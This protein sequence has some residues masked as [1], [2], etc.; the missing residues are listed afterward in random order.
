[1][2]THEHLWVQIHKFVTVGT[3]CSW[4]VFVLLTPP[5]AEWSS[6]LNLGVTGMDHCS[7]GRKTWEVWW[8]TESVWV[9]MPQEEDLNTNRRWVGGGQE[10]ELSKEDNWWSVLWLTQDPMLWAK[11]LAVIEKRRRRGLMVSVWLV[12]GN[13]PFA[14]GDSHIQRIYQ[15]GKGWGRASV[16]TPRRSF[17]L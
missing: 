3:I 2:N 15:R 17:K 4:W 5:Q 7:D 14:W 10:E 9:S 13:Q 8:L 1:M 16:I 12:G 11:E 6:Q